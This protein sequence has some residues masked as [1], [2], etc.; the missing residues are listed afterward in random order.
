MEHSSKLECEEEE[1]VFTKRND[2][3]PGFARRALMC[4]RFPDNAHVLQGV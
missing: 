1:R 2:G 3:G 4:H